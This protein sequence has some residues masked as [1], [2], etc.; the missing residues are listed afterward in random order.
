MYT[1]LTG[2]IEL[3]LDVVPWELGL[4][5][6]PGELGLD[7]VPEEL[8][9]GVVPGELGFDVVPAGNYGSTSFLRRTMARRRSLELGL[10]S[11]LGN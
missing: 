2:G 5:V 11:F 7:V 1:T 9:L 10:T 6:L 3:E 8:G 4:G